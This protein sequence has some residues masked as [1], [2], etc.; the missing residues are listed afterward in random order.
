MT[1]FLTQLSPSLPFP[2]GDYIRT[3]VYENKLRSGPWA[4]LRI[5]LY[6]YKIPF[7][8][9]YSSWDWRKEAES[10]QCSFLWAE[11]SSW[12]NNLMCRAQCSYQADRIIF[13]RQ[14][15][16]QNTWCTRFLPLHIFWKKETFTLTCQAMIFMNFCPQTLRQLSWLAAVDLSNKQSWSSLIGHLLLQ[17]SLR[18]YQ[19]HTCISSSLKCSHWM[20]WVKGFLKH[21]PNIVLGAVEK[22]GTLKTSS[23]P[24][25]C[26]KPLG[27]EN[28]I[29]PL[30]I[31]REQYK[32]IH[33]KICSL[34]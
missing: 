31:F 14:P 10:Q 11:N 2:L 6:K 13:P 25:D 7:V 17:I 34:P 27:R 8:I 29:K 21:R 30:K 9:V 32:C 5:A 4:F 15:W 16:T 3:L 22:M 12:K 1:T 18:P 26:L 19:I 20:S 23:W 33:N 28:K 24:G